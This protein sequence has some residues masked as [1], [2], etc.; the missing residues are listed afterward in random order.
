MVFSP[1]VF[2]PNL[3]EMLPPYSFSFVL[4]YFCIVFLEVTGTKFGGHSLPPK[5]ILVALRRSAILCYG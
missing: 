4:D 2:K 5:T 3:Q 1:L